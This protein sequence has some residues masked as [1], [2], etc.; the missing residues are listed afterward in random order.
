MTRVYVKGCRQTTLAV[1]TLAVVAALALAGCDDWI[2]GG[3][4]GSGGSGT[5]Y[6]ETPRSRYETTSITVRAV[7]PLRAAAAAGSHA[8]VASVTVTV[9][10]EDA[11]GRHQ[12]ALAT[13]DLTRADGGWSGTLSG[14]TVGKSL[15]FTAQALSDANVKL[16]EGSTSATLGAD[17]GAVTIGL[18]SVDDGTANR[19]PGVAAITVSAVEPGAGATVQVSVF[20]NGSEDLDYEFAGGTFAPGTGSVRLSNGTG[21]FSSSYTAPA[22]A[23]R[24]TLHLRVTNTQGHG[25]EVD[26]EIAVR[27]AA[28]PVTDESTLAANLGPVVTSLAGKRTPA[29]VRW[30][31]VAS[32]QGT[33]ATYAWS[34]TGVGSFTD[35]AANPTILAGYAATTTGM[36]QVTVTDATGLTATASLPITAGMFPDAL[37]RGAAE[38][39]INEIDYDTGSDNEFIEVYNAGGSA[40]DLAGYRFDLVD[41]ANDTAYASYAGVGQLAAGGYFVMARQTVFDSAGVPKLLLTDN[42]QNGPDAIR[43]VE[44]ATGRV[45]DSVHYGGSVAGAGEGKPAGRDSG[46]AAESIGR[47][48]SGFDSDDNGLD[49]A[50]MTATPGADNTCTQPSRLPS[51]SA[52]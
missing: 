13:A 50:S 8:D 10:G 6:V 5:A 33:A 43:I 7:T 18:R 31:A 47:C 52:K 22:N 28:S 30:T 17:T 16:F 24:Y 35:V 12:A 38:L 20:G 46:A 1:T 15:T 34:F 2:L 51:G 9:A 3:V 4:P 42:V 37:V 44:T 11:Q 41:G 14:L 27:A 48:P 45:V 19:L 29:G 40:V 49:F 21:A 25:V 39:V 23:G 32:T 36:L 26:F